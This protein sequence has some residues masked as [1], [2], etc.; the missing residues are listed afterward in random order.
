MPRALASVSTSQ[1]SQE[2]VSHLAVVVDPL[3]SGVN[4]DTNPFRRL[5][6]KKGFPCFTLDEIKH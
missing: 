1:A 3:D 4:L 2:L 6:K 5:K